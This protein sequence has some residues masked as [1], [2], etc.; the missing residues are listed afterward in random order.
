MLRINAL[1]LLA[2]FLMAGCGSAPPQASESDIAAVSGKGDYQIGPGDTLNIFVWRNDDLSVTV[3]VR[4]DGKISTP[5]V[6]D[7]EAVGKTPSELARDMEEV[8]AEYIRSPRVNVIVEGFVGTFS[9]QVRVLGQAAQPQSIPYR[10]RMTLLDVMIEVGGL[11]E[12]ASGNRSKLVRVVDGQTQEYRVR[13]DDLVNKGDL[14]Q[15]MLMQ[16]GDVIII[17]EAIF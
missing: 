10:E 15:N 1:A 17:P 2:V 6:E 8:L 7:M 9:E 12:F 3:P 5:L 4:P 16:P 14:D 13:L 11:T